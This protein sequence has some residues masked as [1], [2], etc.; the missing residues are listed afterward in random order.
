[1]DPRPI[2]TR[3]PALA[4]TGTAA[5]QSNA[6]ADARRSGNRAMAASSALSF[7]HAAVSRASAAAV[8]TNVFVAATLSSGPAQ[9]G[10][11][12]SHV[13]ASGESG[14]LVTATV[15]APDCFALAVM[16]MRSSLQ[17]GR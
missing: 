10:R 6:A 1:V 9:I 14:A 13:S 16:A 8:A 12:N 11:T 2:V 5:L 7:V 15:S 17:I 3:L 4:S